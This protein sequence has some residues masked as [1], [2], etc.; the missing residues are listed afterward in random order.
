M[1][2]VSDHVGRPDVASAAVTV[3]RADDG[4]RSARRSTRIAVALLVI[5]C[6]S[7]CESSTVSGLNIRAAPTTASRVVGRLSGAGS[8]VQVECFTRG[9]AI[10]GQTIW[11]RISAPHRGYVT[12]YYVRADS[13]TRTNTP[14]C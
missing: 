13:T 11:Y 14:R 12:G 9:Q 8:S 1:R 6:A 10:H 4:P 7:A 5:V 3:D 2:P